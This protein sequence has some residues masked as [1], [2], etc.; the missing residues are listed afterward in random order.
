MIDDEEDVAALIAEILRR[1]EFDVDLVHSGEAG[2]AAVAKTKYDA[3]LVDV[4]MPGIGGKG[5]LA[6]INQDFP[7]LVSRTAFVTGSTMSP[8]APKDVRDLARAIVGGS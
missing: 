4:K 2:L 6:S 3:V 5:F 8:V 1:D 7:E